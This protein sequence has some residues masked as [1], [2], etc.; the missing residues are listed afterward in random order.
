MIRQ[1]QHSPR[2]ARIE[3]FDETSEDSC[4]PVFERSN[5]FLDVASMSS[6]VCGFDVDDKEVE[7]VIESV[8][9]AIALAFIIG[10]VPTSGGFKFDNFDIGKDTKAAHKVDGGHQSGLEPIGTFER[11]HLWLKTLTPQP[12]RVCV[13]V[14]IGKD[15]ARRIHDSLELRCCCTARPHKRL[16]GQVVGRRAFGIGPISRGHHDVPV[17]NAAMELNAFISER[18][19][20]CFDCGCRTLSGWMST[21]EVD[22]GSVVA[23]R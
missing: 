2:T 20:H 7:P 4:I 15:F 21:S 23:N 5:F 18:F 16:T 22:H 11:W 1:Q 3:G 10:V 17:L 13:N 12:H 9:G 8:D 19:V 6:F 14:E